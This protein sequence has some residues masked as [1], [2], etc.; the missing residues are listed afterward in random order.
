MKLF[1]SYYAN[2]KN[3]PKSYLCIG[4]SRVCPEWFANNDLDNFMFI[5]SNVLA[6]SESLLE[7]IKSNQISQEQYKKEYVEHLY[8][9][10][11]KYFNCDDLGEWAKRLIEDFKD[12]EWEGVVL[13]C[14]ERPEDF[15]HRHIIRN[16]LN[17]VYHIECKEYGI[18]EE[19]NTETSKTL[20]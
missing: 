15:C 2:Y 18:K 8:I 10:L 1:T 13:M 14:Y 6:P 9:S 16:L 5:K 4:I 7:K 3:I 11:K 17:K 19:V 12:T 20:F